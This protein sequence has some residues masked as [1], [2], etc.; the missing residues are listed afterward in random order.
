MYAA[1]RS[2]TG[3]FL[4]EKE[5]GQ[6][7][8]PPGLGADLRRGIASGDLRLHYQP[9][10]RCATGRVESVEALVRWEHPR[11]G[12]LPPDQFI[13]VAEQTGTITALTEWVLEEAIRQCADW[14]G[15][16]L[17]LGVSVNISPITLED[18]HFAD[19][20]TS[21]LDRYDLP[22]ASL[23]LEIT[24]SALLAQPE[25][26]V[27]ALEALALTGVRLAV[28]DFGSGYFSISQLRRL[29]VHQVKLDRSFLA[30]L[31]NERAG[32]L[33]AFLLGLR[34][35]LDVE[36]VAGEVETAATWE[37][38][39]KLGCELALGFYVSRPQSA[40]Q[41]ELWL[42]GTPWRAGPGFPFGEA[43]TISHC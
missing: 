8:E 25:A 37:Q 21:L 10:I 40:E 27:A 30:D 9:V 5:E 7:A 29:P 14:R 6:D 24:E 4:Y 32:K 23:T 35:A 36:V 20:M 13:R 26:T 15:R 18:P 28:D 16:Y 33:L 1:K 17:G 38:L 19:L 34:I 39:V 3:Y 11:L 42:S 2:G 12:L 31:G 41:L 22:A 43:S